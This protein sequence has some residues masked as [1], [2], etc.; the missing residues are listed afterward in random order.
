MQERSLASAEHHVLDP[1]DAGKV[2][3][4]DRDHQ[5]PEEEEPANSLRSFTRM[6]MSRRSAPSAP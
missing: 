1:S 5:A 3:V 4:Y 2:V 6:L